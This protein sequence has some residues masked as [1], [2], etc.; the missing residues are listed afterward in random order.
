MSLQL[1]L[2]VFVAAL[3]GA[4]APNI[5]KRVACWTDGSLAVAY[6]LALDSL[7]CKSRCKSR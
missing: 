5:P 3:V 6:G 1:M 4:L 2:D 7:L